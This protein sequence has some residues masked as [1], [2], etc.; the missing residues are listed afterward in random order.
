MKTRCPGITWKR[1]L[2][3]EVLPAQAALRAIAFPVILGP[4][5]ATWREDVSFRGFRS[6][7]NPHRVFHGRN[8]PFFKD[9]A[10][11]RL[12]NSLC[13]WN[14]PSIRT[15]I[16]NGSCLALPLKA[17]DT[18]FYLLSNVYEYL[19]LRNLKWLLNHNGQ[20]SCK[21]GHTSI[22]TLLL[23][24]WLKVAYTC[25]HFPPFPVSF[26]TLWSGAGPDSPLTLGRAANP[27]LITKS[28]GFSLLLP[29]SARSDHLSH[30]PPSPPDT[31]LYL[32]LWCCNKCSRAS[33]EVAM[34]NPLVRRG[35]LA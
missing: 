14:E 15:A 9:E 35:L 2:L 29:P 1:S 24:H 8:R 17:S 7:V 19:Q 20:P 6:G 4:W 5:K 22:D 26:H 23:S 11:E 13:S 28:N 3:H 30:W 25:W 27:L 10:V 16:Q 18:N 34:A 32:V 33:W 21:R 31:L 12:K